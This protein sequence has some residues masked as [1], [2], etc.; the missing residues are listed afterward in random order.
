MKAVHARPRPAR[1]RAARAFVLT[2][3]ITA[4][5]LAGVWAGLVADVRTR[6]V[7]D[8]YRAE[9]VYAQLAEAVRLPAAEIRA[10]AAL[11]PAPP[12]PPDIDRTAHLPYPLRLLCAFCAA[13]EAEP[14]TDAAPVTA[15]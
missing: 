1:R 9:R 11:P 14:G 13:L 2:F 15:P 10:D 8:G 6:R 3:F 5:L 7:C 12:V 4:I